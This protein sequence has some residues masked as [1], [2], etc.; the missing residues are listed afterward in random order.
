MKNYL[1][2][3]F[4]KKVIIVILFCCIGAAS[5]QFLYARQNSGKRIDISFNAGDIGFGM[6]FKNNKHTSFASINLFNLYIED[7]RTDLGLKLSPFYYVGGGEKGYYFREFSLLNAD[8]YWIPFPK[9]KK[10]AMMVP[11][12]SINYFTYNKQGLLDTSDITF[13]TGWRFVYVGRED[14]KFRFDTYAEVGYRYFDNEHYYYFT[15]NLDLTILAAL[16]LMSR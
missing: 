13:S 12:A 3:G 6:L 5:P 9:V 16:Y 15:L 10:T 11:F 1:S 14:S 4:L 8:I 7:A 2:A